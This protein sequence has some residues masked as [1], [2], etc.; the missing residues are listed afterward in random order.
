MIPPPDPPPPR[1]T[2]RPLPAS[3]YLPGPGVPHPSDGGFRAE[4][5]FDYACD[6]F[7]HRFFWEAHEV[8]E[9]EWR[10][11]DRDSPDAWL[12]Q[13]LILGAAFALKKHQGVEEGAKRLLARCHLCLRAVVD[14]R[15]EVV[16]GIAL[17]ELFR[18]LHAFAEGGPW[19]TLP[20]G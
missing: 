10:R 7:D 5:D 18:R 11:L 19:P 15:G 1:R 20:T 8:W 13:G 4:P 6:L 3:R 17:R 16:R 9:A 14:H 2:T 12:L